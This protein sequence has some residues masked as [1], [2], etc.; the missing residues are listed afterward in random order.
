[1]HLD[2]APKYFKHVRISALALV[3]MV[4]HTRSGGSIE[5]PE[6][7]RTRPHRREQ[8]DTLQPAL[9]ERGLEGK[10]AGRGPRVSL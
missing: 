4:M 1:M 3:K 10:M 9:V 2:Q 6:N 5:V 7:N 8:G